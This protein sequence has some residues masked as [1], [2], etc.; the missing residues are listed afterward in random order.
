MCIRGCE[1]SHGGA[2]LREVDLDAIGLPFSN[3]SGLDKDISRA[4]CP[5]DSN[6]ALESLIS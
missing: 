1:N 5:A 3:A 4:A 2:D 6:P